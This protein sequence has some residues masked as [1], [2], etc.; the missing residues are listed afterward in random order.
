MKIWKILSPKVLTT[1]ERPDN[2]TSATQAK[3]KIT[4]VL[5]S[6]GD[7]R[8]FGGTSKPHYPVIP[9][10]FA[11]GVVTETGAECLNVEKNTRVFLH[12]VIPCRNCPDCLS[13]KPENC[14]SPRTAGV[15]SEGYLREFAVAEESDLSPLPPAVSDKDALLIG[16]ISLCESV[17]DRLDA[18]KGTHIAVFGADVVGNVLAQLLIYHKAVPILVDSDESKLERASQ[19]GIYYTLKADESLKEN[20]LRITGGRFA[21]ASVFCSFSGL[22]AELAF[23]ATA[24]RGIVVCAG[25]EFPEMTAQLKTALDKR[26][27]VTAVTEEAA[28]SAAAINLLVNKAVYPQPLGIAEVPATEIGRLF[29]EQAET[30]EKSG[31]AHYGIVNML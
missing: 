22:S 23:K 15:S 21:A 6:D 10:R 4:R 30:A 2:I 25:F 31:R 1:E 8:A 7:F 12:D 24:E 18:P 27:T 29:S 26:L 28:G 17:I 11:V 9:G 16:V 20:L 13:G 14:T 3:V 5:L 19:C